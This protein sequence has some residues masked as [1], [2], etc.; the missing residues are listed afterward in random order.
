VSI[1]ACRAHKTPQN[2]LAGVAQIQAQP[3]P[4]AQPSP[5]T[6][7]AAPLAPEEV[8]NATRFAFGRVGGLLT[9][10]G[11]AGAALIVLPITRRINK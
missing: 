7:I 10:L 11:I 2:N 5:V 3:L 4:T 8:T 9:V 6:T 1:V